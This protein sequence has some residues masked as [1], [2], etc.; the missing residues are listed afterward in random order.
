MISEKRYNMYIYNKIKDRLFDEEDNYFDRDIQELDSF[1]QTGS[2]VWNTLTQIANLYEFDMRKKFY[3]N[4]EFMTIW[5]KS[6]IGYVDLNAAV[7][8]AEYVIFCCIVDKIL[9]SKRFS[10]ETK[11]DL[12]KYI[13]INSFMHNVRLKIKEQNLCCIFE[14]VEDIRDYLFHFRKKQL[15][16]SLNEEIN[17]A[18]VSECFMGTHNLNYSITDDEFHLLIDKSVCFESSALKLSILGQNENFETLTRL[19]GEIFW[20]IDDICDLLEDYKNK[21]INSLLYYENGGQSVDERLLYAVDNIDYY[22]DILIEKVEYLRKCANDDI[23]TFVKEQI[24]WWLSGA[25]RIVES[26]D[27]SSN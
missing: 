13:N 8:A 12:L 2:D 17:R 4:V 9:D 11:F 16:E 23:Y 27:Q 10:D 26:Q 1:F 3:I 18:L 15:C 7:I 22:I 20:L 19:V 21:R 24:W 5:Q 6:L 14:L 25:R